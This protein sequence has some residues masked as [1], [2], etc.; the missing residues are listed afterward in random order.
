M[1]KSVLGPVLFLT[2]ALAVSSLGWPP[3]Q[4][5][6]APDAKLEKFFQKKRVRIA[7]TDSGLGGLSV[8]AEAAARLKEAGTFQTADFIFYNALFSAEGGYNT[9]ETRQEK[10]D[11]FQRAME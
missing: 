3:A 6:S 10:V 7:V 5:M 1:R 8:M 4:E 2:A 11:I 9:L